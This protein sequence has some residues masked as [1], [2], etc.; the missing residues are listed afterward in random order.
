MPYIFI[1][2]ELIKKIEKK[3]DKL[4]ADWDIDPNERHTIWQMVGTIESG[5]ETRLFYDDNGLVFDGWNG[6]K[7]LENKNPNPRGAFGGFYRTDK[8]QMVGWSIYLI[9]QAD[10]KE[11]QASRCSLVYGYQFIWEDCPH[12]WGFYSFQDYYTPEEQAEAA[13]RLACQKHVK[14]IVQEPKSEMSW[15]YRVVV[16]TT[17]KKS[18]L[19]NEWRQRVAK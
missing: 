14:K 12:V 13:A 7:G 4:M 19:Q 17:Q 15:M 18:G 1:N 2:P 10:D 5:T 8:H 11:S 9:S 6:Y 16:E 3:V